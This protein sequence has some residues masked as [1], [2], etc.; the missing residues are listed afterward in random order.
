[1]AMALALWYALINVGCMAFKNPH[2]SPLEV[3]TNMF[4]VEAAMV[5]S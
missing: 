4:G 1:M 2:D 3:T 5:T